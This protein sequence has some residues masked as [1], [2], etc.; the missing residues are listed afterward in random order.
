MFLKILLQGD[1]DPF[2]KIPRP[3]GVPDGLGV[4]FLDEPSTA[5]QSNA[6]VIELQLRSRSKK[7]RSGHVTVRSIEN[8]SKNTREIDQWTQS[9]EEIHATKPA[10]EVRYRHKMPSLE[11]LMQTI[12]NEMENELRNGEIPSADIDF[13]L[14]EYARVLCSLLGIPVYDGCLVESI[15]AMLSMYIECRENQVSLCEFTTV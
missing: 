12:P 1:V 2:L 6:A 4:T 11:E 5:N 15:H 10:P 13:T 14:E 9:V 3:D 8:A 7:K